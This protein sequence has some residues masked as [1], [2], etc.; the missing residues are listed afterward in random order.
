MSGKVILPVSIAAFGA[1]SK[2]FRAR[3]AQPPRKNW[4]V[5]LCALMC[6]LRY[7]GSGVYRSLN[8][9][10]AAVVHDDVLWCYPHDTRSR[11]RR[12]KSTPFSGAGF[13]LRFFV[14]YTSGMKISGAKI[15]VAVSYV[16]DE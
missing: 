10:A 16:N 4:P 8:A 12:H 13:R 7:A 6:R 1:L 15:N 3:M 9:V 5:R 14:P 11:N 2:I